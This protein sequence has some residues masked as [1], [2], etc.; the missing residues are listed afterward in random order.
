M[1]VSGHLHTTAAVPLK[2]L[3]GPRNQSF[4][5][6]LLELRINTRQS[7]PGPLTVYLR[8]LFL[9]GIQCTM[10]VTGR[11]SAVFRRVTYHASWRAATN[12]CRQLRVGLWDTASRQ[13]VLYL[14]RYDV[15]QHEA[16][17]GTC[18]FVYAVAWNTSIDRRVLHWITVWY[19]TCR[20]RHLIIVFRGLDC[21]QAQ[22]S[23]C[24]R[25]CRRLRISF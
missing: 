13:P 17:W 10:D 2:K 5:L 3:V 7:I 23:Y 16:W 18:R 24:Q 19:V 4:L 8:L 25:N 15:I 6:I 22:E 11:H 21:L 12:R 20:V 14:A 1:E 9:C